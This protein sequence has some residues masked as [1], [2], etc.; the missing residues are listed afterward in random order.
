DAVQNLTR[1][2]L[3]VGTSVTP[4]EFGHHRI[5]ERR[6]FRQKMMELKDKTDVTI[7]ESSQFSS[8]PLEN[9]LVF[10]EH[11][12]SRRPVQTAE[13]M[14]QSALSS[15]RRANDGDNAAGLD[16]DVNVLENQNLRCRSFVDLREISRLDH[17]SERGLK[18]TTT[19]RPDGTR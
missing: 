16:L 4:D 5:L 11:I 19:S 17:W 1:L 8:V 6:E 12:T 9:I 13:Q 10:K 3:R 7:S 18:P 2:Q 15:T 14:K